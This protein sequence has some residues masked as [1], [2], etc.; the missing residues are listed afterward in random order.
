MTDGESSESPA[1]IVCT[2]AISSSGRVRFEQDDY[3]FGALRA[4]ASGFLLMQLHFLT[5]QKT[6]RHLGWSNSFCDGGPGRNEEARS[7]QFSPGSAATI[8]NQQGEEPMIIKKARFAVGIVTLSLIGV[9]VSS[10]V[11]AQ[12]GPKRYE[13]GSDHPQQ[14]Q[15]AHLTGEWRLNTDLSDDPAKVMESMHSE[16]G[17]GSG[18]GRWMHGGGGGGGMDPAK[19]QAMRSAMEAPAKLTIAEADG[20]VTFTDSEGRSQTFATTNKKEQHSIENVTADVKT[21]WED[22]RLVKETSFD[23]GLKLT[24]TYSL[25]PNADQLQVLVKMN[26]SQMSREVSVK[27]VYDR[28]RRR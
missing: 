18:R 15:T 4:G 10:A 16:R 7:P 21:K 24:E 6:S 19:M 20:S 27:R 3:I 5:L 14:G 13:F 8:A 2:A 22:G 17:G 11:F 1:A 25:V 12:R 23:D 26:V 9:L 28:E